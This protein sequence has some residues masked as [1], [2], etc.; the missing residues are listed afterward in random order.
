MTLP[1]PAV[2]EPSLD[3]ATQPIVEEI[4]DQLGF[5]IVPNLLRV[6]LPVP[7]SL[8]AVWQSIQAILLNGTLARTYKE[9]VGVTVAGARGSRY[10]ATIHR[11]SLEQQ[12]VSSE[13]LTAV[14]DGDL[15]ELT[16]QEQAGLQYALRVTLQP[17]EVTPLELTE[18][19][20]AGFSDEEM[21]ELCTTIGLFGL[22]C[23]LA[24]ATQ[25]P[26]DTVA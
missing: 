6:L 12:G 1:I 2:H 15:S 14:C 4:T 23:A 19:R 10:V 9:L 5:G 8:Q 7:H 18:L 25:I 3:E 24:D 16:P 21:L 26:P 11:Y 17:M 22:L 20:A 13:L